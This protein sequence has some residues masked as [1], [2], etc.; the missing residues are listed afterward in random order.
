MK[1]D[2]TAKLSRK[3]RDNKVI[4]K[5]ILVGKSKLIEL[6]DSLYFLRI[7]INE[8][9]VCLHLSHLLIVFHLV[10]VR[11]GKDLQMQM[12]PMQTL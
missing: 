5:H 1:Y 2:L 12:Q 10:M 9:E 6:D 11:V 4:V 3:L 7:Q 8:L